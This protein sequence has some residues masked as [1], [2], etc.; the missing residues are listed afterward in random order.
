VFL[1][2][3]SIAIKIKDMSLPSSLLSEVDFLD[4]SDVEQK[5]DADMLLACLMVGEY[6]SEK[7]ESPTFYV[8][9]RM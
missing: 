5:E 1:R 3:L 2:V 9:N 4:D 6:F 7:E 8:R